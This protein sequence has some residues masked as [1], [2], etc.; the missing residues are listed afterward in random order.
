MVYMKAM[1]YVEVFG[2][3]DKGEQ[4]IKQMKIDYPDTK[5]AK[6]ADQILASLNEQAAAEKSRMH[7]RSEHRFRILQKRIW[8]GSP[9]RL[10]ALR[11]KLFW[12]IFGRPGAVPA[13]G[14]CQMSSP[15]TKSIMRMVLK[16][17]A[18]AWIRIAINSMLSSSK[19][20]A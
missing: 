14:N 4:I 1:L 7:W 19:R 10:R 15:P 12:L 9:S 3:T 6:K 5:I 17:S 16:S 8:T 18:S 13:A 20:T 11:A 2:E